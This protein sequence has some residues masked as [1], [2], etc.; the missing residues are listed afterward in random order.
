MI[1]TL[2]RAAAAAS[3]RR[4]RVDVGAR[5]SARRRRRGAPPA[6]R[7][8][9]PRADVYYTSLPR[10]DLGTYAIFAIESPEPGRFRSS[11]H[12]TPPHARQIN[13]MTV[14]E[15]SAPRHAAV[16]SAM[17]SGIL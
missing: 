1:M 11:A 17:V 7:V 3:W 16:C 15:G 2:A 10:L 12:L 14:N 8:V 5:A 6:W 9:A 4:R 13:G